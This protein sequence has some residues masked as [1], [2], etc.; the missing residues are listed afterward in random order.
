MSAREAHFSW[1][2]D[3]GTE[4]QQAESEGRPKVATRRHGGTA[5]PA[6]RFVN[7][8]RHIRS[9]PSRVRIRGKKMSYLIVSN[10]VEDMDVS[11]GA[12]HGPTNVRL[13]FEVANL[14]SAQSGQSRS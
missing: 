10:A 6:T 7:P 5:M 8:I 13:A 2:P 14:R 3:F 12:E 1:R 9:E 4:I 11:L